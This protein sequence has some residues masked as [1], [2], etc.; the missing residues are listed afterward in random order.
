MH[1]KKQLMVKKYELYFFTHTHI[2]T[3]R[4]YNILYTEL[5]QLSYIISYESTAEI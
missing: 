2:Y 5:L 4:T 3:L 1:T